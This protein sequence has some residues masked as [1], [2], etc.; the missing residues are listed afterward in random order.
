MRHAN[1][2]SIDVYTLVES[3]NGRAPDIV[4]AVWLFSPTEAPTR[5]ATSGQ[6]VAGGRRRIAPAVKLRSKDAATVG[7]VN[8]DE[9]ML[10]V[11]TRLHGDAPCP[12]HPLV[13]LDVHLGEPLGKRTLMDANGSVDDLAVPPPAQYGQTVVVPPAG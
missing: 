3:G 7:T 13:S 5:D 4:P 8:E 2:A 11:E 6:V 1:P 9:V 12:S 10:A